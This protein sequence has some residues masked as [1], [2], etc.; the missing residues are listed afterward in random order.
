MADLAR[1]CRLETSKVLTDILW[2]LI[3]I[4]VY[5]LLVIERGWSLDDW[6]RWVAESAA[7]LLLR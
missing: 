4:E 2:T 3:A 7:A 1:V 6:E 5:D